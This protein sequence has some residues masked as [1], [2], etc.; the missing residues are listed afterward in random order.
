MKGSALFDPPPQ[1][2]CCERLSRIAWSP[3]VAFLGTFG[4]MLSPPPYA[5]SP[6]ET[7]GTA[8]RGACASRIT[9]AALLHRFGRFWH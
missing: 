2:G 3:P 5:A 1:E 8:G 9:A 6:G 4:E 7:R